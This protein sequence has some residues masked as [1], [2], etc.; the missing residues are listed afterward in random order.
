MH[1][2][3]KAVVIVHGVVL[4]AAVVPNRQRVGLPDKTAG[5]LGLDLVLKKEVEDGRAF[6]FGHADDARGV[7]H[8]DIQGFAPCFGVRAHQRVV[9]QIGLGRVVLAIGFDAV[10]AGFGHIGLGRAAD[11]HQ[12]IQQRFHRVRQRVPGHVLVGKQGVT[13]VGG[14]FFGQQHGAHGGL[15]QVGGVGVPDATKVDFFVFEF[16]DLDD[17]GEA[18]QA[19][20]KGVLHGLAQRVGK[21]HELFGR[22]VLAPEKN[23]LVLQQGCADFLL[24]ICRD[25][26]GQ[27]D[28]VELGAQ[29]T[30]DSVNDHVFI[31]SQTLG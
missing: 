18:I 1:D 5:E 25:G 14:D 22:E 15:L 12:A 19:F 4:G 7:R 11:A 2:P 8:I 9:S 21:L 27:I 13:A 3:A 31:V 20:D 30:C 29:S 26:P 16:L 17:A 24:Q 6:G 23:D 10:F 28:P